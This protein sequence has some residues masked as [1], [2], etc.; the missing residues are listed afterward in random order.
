L[1][2]KETLFN[3]DKEYADAMISHARA[4]APDEC[5]GILAG[6]GG[7]IAQFYRATNAEHSPFRYSVYPEE[8]I[9][10]YQEIE[11]RGW[12]L[13]GIY[14]S[15]TSTPAYPSAT[16]IKY[17]FWSPALYFIISVVDPAQPVIRAF[18]IKKGIVVEEELKIADRAK[19]G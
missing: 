4:E 15:H 9:R 5:C 12:E 3:L 13:L 7:K 19:P 1:G 8:L 2:V 17:A 14:H 10:I 11:E 18:R 6:K 16:D